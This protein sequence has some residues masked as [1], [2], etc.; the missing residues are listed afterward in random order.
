MVSILTKTVMMKS[1][2]HLDEIFGKST[3]AV[4]LKLSCTLELL[5]D[6]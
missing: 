5:G 3:R 6:A 4:L 2:A 1:Q